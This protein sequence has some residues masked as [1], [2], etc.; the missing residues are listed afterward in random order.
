MSQARGDK[1]RVKSSAS[2]ASARS[3]Q[4][5]KKPQKRNQRPPRAVRLSQAERRYAP[6]PQPRPGVSVT[7]HIGGPK[8]PD[9]LQA[10]LR[11]ADKRRT[12]AVAWLA[13]KFQ[14]VAAVLGK[15]PLAPRL[16]RPVFAA[17]VLG[18]ALGISFGVHGIFSGPLP[19]TG[20]AVAAERTEPDFKPLMPSADQANA[21]RYDGKRNMVMYSTTFSGAR[22]TVSQQGLPARFRQDPLSLKTT[23]DSIQ[24]K[25]RLDTASGPMYIA[26]SEGGDQ[27]ALY[28]NKTVLLFIHSDRKLDDPSWIAFIEL[29]KPR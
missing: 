19:A 9:W 6:A 10:A 24:A 13:P 27:M 20:T 16:R 11:A 21:T 28:A 17:L 2:A 15:I 4:T 7:I 8:L 1:P 14:P 3:A 12:S 18:L 22:L 5:A 29:L 26:T 23:A 25:Q